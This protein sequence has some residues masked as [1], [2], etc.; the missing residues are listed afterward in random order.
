MSDVLHNEVQTYSYA[1][2]ESTG[3]FIT[4]MDSRQVRMSS[5]HSL[6]FWHH[7]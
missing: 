7:V 3:E 1:T 2:P 4:G 5:N 6:L